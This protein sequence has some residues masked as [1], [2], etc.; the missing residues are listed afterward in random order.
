MHIQ[1]WG[2]ARTVT[3]SMHLL[4]VNGRNLLLDCGLYQGK[5]QIAFERNR[6][7]P[8]DPT[9]IDAVVLSH[10]HIDHSG[11]LP[12][13]VRGGFEGPIY[14]TSA[15]RDLCAYMLQ[16]SAH[17]H[18]SDVKYVNK[19][20]RRE[21]KRPF[22]PL[23]T[24]ADAVATLERF[25]TVPVHRTFS[26][27][28]G[29][30]ASFW[31][32]GHILGAASV[33]LDIEE[34]GR[35]RRLVFSGDIGRPSMPIIRDPENVEGA[36][37]VIMECTYGQ[38]SHES[39]GEAKEAL[40]EAVTAVTERAGKLLIPAFAVG[41]TQEL[42]YRLGE[43]EREGRLPPID[44]YVDSPLAI[45]AT[46]VVRLHP[47]CF[48]AEMREAVDAETD[49]DPL[50]FG[51]LYYVRSAEQSKQLNTL[52]GAAVIISA[53]GMI[54]GGRILH[55]VKNHGPKASTIVLFVGFQAEHTL[56]RRILEGDRMVKVFGERVDLR[57]EVRRINGYSAHADR[58][59]LLDWARAIREA[60]DVRRTFLVHGEEEVA[61]SFADELAPVM[62]GRVDVPERGQLFEL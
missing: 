24:R 43:L 22:E 52:E 44:V 4:R 46:D 23:Y 59:E 2:A 15:T 17:I 33:R 51:R 60:G 30:E 14:A 53:S 12:S 49:N 41:R 7:L 62:G 10:A 39:T 8:F 54:E 56:G 42:V 5:R 48:D 31:R 13:L 25:I 57:A 61:L 19:R 58:G 45:N 20:R 32:A 36:D 37:A 40:L 35:R 34:S 27:I 6:N 47:E 55:H 29:V 11:N 18:E 50:S 3:G 21:G 9:Q 28:R 16:D 38:R 26:P 1:F